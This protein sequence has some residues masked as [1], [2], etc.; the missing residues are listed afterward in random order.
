MFEIKNDKLRALVGI[1]TLLVFIATIVLVP[2]GLGRALFLLAEYPA[3]FFITWGF[4]LIAL[5]IIGVA[6]AVGWALCQIGI[7]LGNAWYG[8]RRRGK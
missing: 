1:A 4:G 8:P 7:A 6:L 2:F 3:G 5:I